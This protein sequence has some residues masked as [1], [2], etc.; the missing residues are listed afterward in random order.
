MPGVADLA[1]QVPLR[2]YQARL[3]DEALTAEGT[4]D[5]RLH[6]VAPPGAGKT[7]T[8]LELIR[9][10]GARALVL[11][12]TTTIVEQWRDEV[13]LFLPD[14]TA[15]DRYVTTDRDGDA[16][17]TVLT[18]QALAS[19][20]SPEQAL[21][22][23]ALEQWVDELVLG[24]EARDADDARRHLAAL[25]HGDRGF[26]R[27]L[28]RRARR[29]RDAM[30]EAEHES[31]HRFL[32]PNAQAL[33]ERLVEHGVG[34][35]VLDECHHLL[36]YW[37]VVVS[38]L[39]DR[40]AERHGSVDVVGLTATLPTPDSARESENYLRLLGEVDVDIPT[41]LVVKEGA[42]APYRDL[43]A[44]VQPL[45]HEQR[46]LADAQ[47]IFEQQLTAITTGERFLAWVTGAALGP[48][49]AD[50]HGGD[51]DD[52][53]WRAWLRD[54][55]RFAGAVLRAHVHGGFTL[56]AGVPIP[57]DAEEPFTT[58]DRL[59]LVERFA[60]TELLPDPSPTA[61][62]QLAD[63]QAALEGFGLSVGPTG[64]RQRRPPG[65]LILALTE[66]KARMTAR[67][68]AAE[69]AAHGDGLRALV[70]TDVDRAATAAARL[71]N[72]L[73]EAAGSARHLHETLVDADDVR[74]LAPVLVT[75]TT[76][77]VGHLH[78]ERI[79]AALRTWYAERGIDVELRAELVERAGEPSLAQELVGT[80]PGW[81]PRTYVPAMTALFEAGVTRCLVGTRGLFAEG[82]DAPSCNTL[83]DLTGITATTTTRQLRG[84]TLRLDPA[85]PEKVAHNWDVV[86]VAPGVE[87]GDNDLQ[88]FVR[89][90][91][92]L[93][94]VIAT[95]DR[96]GEIV[97]GVEH[98]DVELADRLQSGDVGWAELEAATNRAFRTMAERRLAREAWED[99]R[100][101]GIVRP[102]SVVRIRPRGAL[103]AGLAAGG[104]LAFGPDTAGARRRALRRLVAGREVPVRRL[105][106]LLEALGRATLVAL[107]ETGIAPSL[108]GSHVSARPT[109]ARIEVVAV[110]P[111]A[112]SHDTHAFAVA[113]TRLLGDLDQPR[114]L[115]EVGR[116]RLAH[117]AVPD[118]LARSRARADRLARAVDEELGRARAVYAHTDEGRR[119]L[120]DAW[121]RQRG[122]FA[123]SA[124]DRWV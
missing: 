34:T 71:R 66:A 16:P 57:T 65:D 48:A 91:D 45:P 119:I 26:R 55:H 76:V 88:R 62:R 64:L 9:R 110:G 38:D 107:V 72:V 78:A 97:R 54:D 8:G 114:Y 43:A 121:A 41:P 56:P 39:I 84:R 59:L 51:L 36:D 52:T 4:S 40:L 12:P 53:A 30:L 96:R 13:R 109:T 21:L 83:V 68:L 32:H 37:A 120:V 2:R 74:F 82:W 90:H 105:S 113:M 103:A 22:D 86:C 80:R 85:S 115:L 17:I 35:V 6:L 111:A 102:E 67:I 117:L 7:V 104:G 50:R 29:L 75:G 33:V 18:Y 81:S 60:V 5:G 101:S 47:A 49:L 27:E 112:T 94:G 73:D 24:N 87:R 123:V 28:R 61:T 116:R 11:A 93:W 20:A 106:Q 19:T 95:G 3:L 118:E 89:R 15:I 63:L 108:A 14:P 99:P 122:A 1:L 70:V 44:F 58:E 25:E 23:A 31:V 69:S 42:L 10:L 100:H 92:G 124:F 79:L 46:F 77:R 98:V